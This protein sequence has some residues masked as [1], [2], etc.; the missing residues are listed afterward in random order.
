MAPRPS[1]RKRSTKLSTSYSAKPRKEHASSCSWTPSISSSVAR[2]PA[3]LHRHLSQPRERRRPHGLLAD[4]LQSR[5]PGD[6]LR[7]METMEHLI[8]L[9]DPARAAAWLAELQSLEWTDPF[10]RADL[11]GA[12]AGLTATLAAYS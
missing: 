5:P 6:P 10:A 4:H 7:A 12:V 11:A 2:A 8:G 3:I 1:R 9:E